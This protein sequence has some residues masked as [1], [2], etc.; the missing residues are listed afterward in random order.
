ME[1]KRIKSVVNL[2]APKVFENIRFSES[3]QF[4]LEEDEAIAIAASVEY[5]FSIRVL[6]RAWA[7]AGQSKTIDSVRT[8]TRPF[9]ALR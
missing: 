6:C 4:R 7:W 9:I 2:A 5:Y 1:A 3:V 8:R